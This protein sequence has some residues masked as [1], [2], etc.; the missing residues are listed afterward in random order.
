MAKAATVYR[1]GECGWC[2]P[3]WVGR[4]GECQEWGTV[5]QA[6]SPRRDVVSAGPVSQSARP[7]GAVEL[8]AARS[9]PTGVDEFD[10]T[11]GGGLVQGAVILLAGEPGVGKS[12][13]LLE[14]TATWALNAGRALYVTG[15]ES[16]AQVR[17]RA[18][19]TGALADD[20]FLAAET[21][22][23]AVLTH[24]DEVKPSLLV[25]DSVQTVA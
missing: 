21:D 19:R 25:L 9:R 4:G 17:L 8:K 6:G 3:K 10:R 2:T 1:C 14:V 5:E 20:L 18:E 22:L 15:E 23:S 13:L 24:I 16:T 12:T 11:L 7:I